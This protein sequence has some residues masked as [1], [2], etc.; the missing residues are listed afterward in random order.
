MCATQFVAVSL[1]VY[2]AAVLIVQRAVAI[3]VLVT[4]THT[5]AIAVILKLQCRGAR[6]KTVAA[7]IKAQACLKRF[8]GRFRSPPTRSLVYFG[9][10]FDTT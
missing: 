3:F 10:E 9:N 2:N 5:P 8:L 7:F 1:S 6:I 4:H